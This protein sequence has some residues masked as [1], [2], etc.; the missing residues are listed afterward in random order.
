MSA[1]LHM[2]EGIAIQERQIHISK[3]LENV[4]KSEFDNQKEK[5]TYEINSFQNQGE[6]VSILTPSVHI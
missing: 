2:C 4:S 1:C 6:P 5:D 3:C